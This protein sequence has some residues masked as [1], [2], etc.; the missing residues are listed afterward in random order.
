MFLYTGDLHFGHRD[1]IF[2]DHRPFDDVDEMDRAL[3]RLWNDRVLTDDHVYILGDVCY[4]NTHPEEWYLRQLK[5]HKHLIIG[6]HDGSLLNNPKAMRYLESVEQIAEIDDNGNTIVLCHY[7]MANW[8]GYRGGTWHIHGHIHNQKNE[9]FEFLK[10][11]EKA[12]NAGCMLN[13]YTP[14]SFRE[15]RRNNET[16]KALS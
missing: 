1:V 13:R 11:K 2:F 9:A 5:G 10:T 3:I 6:N 7:P 15:L 4:Q 12:L 14:V 8:N 16:F